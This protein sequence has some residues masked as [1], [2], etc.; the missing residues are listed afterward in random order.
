ME[1]TIEDTKKVEILKNKLLI[2][3]EQ[4]LKEE[5]EFLPFGLIQDED[6]KFRLLSI[7]NDDDDKYTTNKAVNSIKAHIDSQVSN[8]DE[9]HS[10]GF[11]QDFLINDSDAIQL[12]L[13]SKFSEGW[14]SIYLPYF[15]QEN[16]KI[17]YGSI[18]LG[19]PM[20]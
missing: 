13:I 4:L 14:I 5:D 8:V 7:S 12:N 19:E 18:I 6:G 17:T 15:I 2:K 9:N 16:R 10:G 1:H 11:C 3:V 20:E